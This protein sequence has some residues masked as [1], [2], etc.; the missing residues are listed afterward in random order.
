MDRQNIH[1]LIYPLAVTIVAAA[2]LASLGVT[3]QFYWSFTLTFLTVACVLSEWLV[4]KLP[5]GDS[6]SPSIILVLLALVFD[7]EQPEP[8]RRAIG[9]MEVIFLG[10]L[11]GY[12]LTHRP[13]LMRWLFYAAHYVWAA[14]IAGLVFAIVSERV[15]MWLLSSFHLPAVIAYT[16]VF[17][18]CS[19]LLVG[20]VNK[21][22]LQ[23]ERLPQANLLYT[24]FLAPIALIVYYFF[25]TRD[26]PLS[27]LLILALPLLGVLYTFRLY[28]NIDTTYGE[29]RQLYAISQEFIAAMSQ[30]ETIQKITASIEQA[31]SQLVPQL[32]ACLVYVY[33]DESNEYLL[34]D[35]KKD[36]PRR[37]V[38]GHGLLGRLVFEG[39]GQIVSDV[40]QQDALTPDERQWPAKTSILSHPLFAEQQ[41]VGLL[42][43]IRYGKRFTAEEFRLVGIIANQVGVTL[44]NARMYEHSL[45]LA[46]KDRL[47]DV[48]NQ[49]AFTQRSQRIMSQAR[50]ANQ[51]VAL[52]YGDIDDFGLLNNTFGHAT[53]DRVL[54]GVA[55]AMK[56]VVGSWGLVGR[57]AGEEFFIL[58]PHTDD[59]EAF[60]VADEIRR[61]VQ[62]LVF[63]SD[64][65]REVRATISTGVAVFPRDAG[66]FFSLRKQADRAAYLAKRMGKNRVCLYE[67]R[68]EF[69]EVAA[70][71]PVITG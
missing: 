44:H 2:L 21:R 33:N 12:G 67:D 54:I 5:Q 10:S 15:S 68:K 30:E 46:D 64:D 18:L 14:F 58:L 38:P 16:V 55:D 71:E 52:L 39:S 7:F 4:I 62:D 11:L 50:T 17:S 60:Q 36:G 13:P 41:Q 9:A 70:K 45:Q 3:G 37:I 24:I 57:S 69:I 35:P 63:R 8:A 53:G 22:I 32:D 31:I 34:V 6:L 20:P 19:M 49:A 26:L 61:R 59:H 56:E 25:V 27:S 42:A 23:G 28:V 48:L 29:V 66:D 65:Q 1:T 47:L 40:T 43:M 51:P